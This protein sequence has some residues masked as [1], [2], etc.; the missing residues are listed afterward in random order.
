[1]L[2]FIF[3]LF[4]PLL[5][6]SLLVSAQR[7]TMSTL[8]SPTTAPKIVSVVKAS[9]EVKLLERVAIDVISAGA[10]TLGIAPGMAQFLKP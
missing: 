7:I 8:P 10:A 1:M 6:P 3:L 9:P 4:S 2:I 5:H